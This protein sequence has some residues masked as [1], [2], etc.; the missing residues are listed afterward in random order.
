MGLGV[1]AAVAALGGLVALGGND[2]HPR[3][4][5]PAGAGAAEMR[6]VLGAT[7]VL[8]LDQALEEDGAFGQQYPC[9]R[10][11]QAIDRITLD[12][13]GEARRKISAVD[14]GGLVK[15]HE[16]A[17]GPVL[18][19]ERPR[20]QSDALSRG[21]PEVLD[22]EGDGGVLRY[23]HAPQIGAPENRSRKDPLALDV[24]VRSDLY[25]INAL[26]MPKGSLGCLGSAPGLNGGISRVVRGLERGPR[27]GS[28]GAED[29]KGNSALEG[30][31][32]S[33]IVSLPSRLLVNLRRSRL[34][35]AVLV[36]LGALSF[37]CA[38]IL[39]ARAL[40]GIGHR[41]K[42]RWIAYGYALSTVCVGC[43]W[44]AVG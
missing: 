9:K 1:L 4:Y 11:S 20:S 29:Q 8:V 17:F 43:L 18:A 37:G 33:L 44:L 39:F 25:L 28:A 15:V 3:L 32:A 31:G 13:S 38:G 5:L 34:S 36:G 30:G 22:G 24:D 35:T 42:L 23:D 6:L 26:V 10:L 16:A 21:L 14:Y 19:D 41:R 27:G 2:E 7:R 40:H 12:F